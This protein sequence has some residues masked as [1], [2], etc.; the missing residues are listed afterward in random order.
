METEQQQ[1]GKVHAA[2]LAVMAEIGAVGKDGKNTEQHYSFR[3][4]DAVTDAV[5]P[6]LVKH[7]LY[8][9]PLK[10]LTD[11]LGPGPNGKGYRVR[12]KI[13]Y[14]ITHIDGSFSDGEVTGEGV[15]YGDKASNKSMAVSFKYF[16]C[17]TFCIPIHDPDSDPDTHSPEL[18]PPKDHGSQR[19][20]AQGQRAPDAT[21]PDP[22][23]QA[24]N[25]LVALLKR[26]GVSG[27]KRVLPWLSDQTSPKRKVT[28]LSD[29]T[30]AE[31]PAIEKAAKS[32]PDPGT[33]PA[34]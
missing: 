30:E 13:V 24:L 6:L 15:D 12:Q 22:K 18:G 4:V 26:K 16:L 29:I 33:Q 14:R 34:E 19:P 28:K 3:S 8:V 5:H 21:T 27:S 20:P 7:Q 32:L 31:F 11:E 25:D 17:Q 9:R 10:I 1:P 2:I 23:V